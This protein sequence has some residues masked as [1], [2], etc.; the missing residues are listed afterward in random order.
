MNV[1]PVAEL[2][3]DPTW[4]DGVGNTVWLRATVR[5]GDPRQALPASDPMQRVVTRPIRNQFEAFAFEF[6]FHCIR[7]FVMRISIPTGTLR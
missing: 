3:I 5:A 2:T 6:S 4:T 7:A 1:H